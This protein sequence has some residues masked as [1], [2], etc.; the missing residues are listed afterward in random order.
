[1]KIAK[2]PGKN[3]QGIDADSRNESEKQKMLL[4]FAWHLSTDKEHSTDCRKHAWEDLMLPSKSETVY[5]P[6]WF[7]LKQILAAVRDI[8]YKRNELEPMIRFIITF[9]SISHQAPSFE[10]S[11]NNKGSAVRDPPCPVLVW[12]EKGTF[13]VIILHFQNL[14]SREII[15]I[16]LKAY[17]QF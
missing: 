3:L 15:L 4:A 8:F 7:L 1:M 9:C 5:P 10:A 11:P 2:D 6:A 16:G 13:L 12:D 17:F 14:L